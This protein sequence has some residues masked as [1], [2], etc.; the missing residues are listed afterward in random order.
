MA[1]P[2]HFRTW[3]LGA[4][5]IGILFLVINLVLT[6]ITITSNSIPW[7]FFLDVF[8]STEGD[9]SRASARFAVLVWGAPILLV[10]G[11][12]LLIVDRAGA[13]STMEKVYQR[14]MQGGYAAGWASIGA[15]VIVERNQRAPVGVLTHPTQQSAESASLAAFLHQ[16]VLTMDPQSSNRLTRNLRKIRFT[17][18]ALPVAAAFPDVNAP[19][20]LTQAH[21]TDPVVVVPLGDVWQVL[22]LKKR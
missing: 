14:Y 22:E 8:L 17:E 13:A 9:S 20:L 11:A 16:R 2:D 6:I 5:G 7:R 21:D 15:S 4:I 12:V 19:N 3:G 18:R 1:R 10:I